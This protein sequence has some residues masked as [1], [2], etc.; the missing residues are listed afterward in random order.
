MIGSLIAYRPPVAWF[1]TEYIDLILL[2]AVGGTALITLWHYFSARYKVKK[3]LAAGADPDTDPADA[4]KLSLDAGVFDRAPDLDVD[5]THCRSVRGLLLRPGI[6][7]PG[8]ERALMVDDFA[9]L[10]V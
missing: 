9:A 8:L 5:G 10:A 2:A 1:V 4:E 3:A 6:L 7:G